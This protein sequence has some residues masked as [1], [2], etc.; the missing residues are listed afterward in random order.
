LRCSWSPSS[1]VS[2]NLIAVCLLAGAMLIGGGPG[3]VAPIMETAAQP[4]GAWGGTG[5]APPTAPGP[6]TPPSSTIPRDPRA[7]FPP[8][9]GPPYDFEPPARYWVPGYYDP[10]GNWVFGYYRYESP[11]Y[12]PYYYYPYPPT[13]S[14]PCPR[15]WVPG[16]YDA[17]GSWVFGYYR[18]EC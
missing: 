16:H 4:P 18:Y 6:R 13:V 3:P 15:V 10:Y 7:F 5:V 9:Y 14:N 2:R 8:P 11:L 12:Y 1:R 17:N